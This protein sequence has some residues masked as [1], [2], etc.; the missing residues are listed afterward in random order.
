MSVRSSNVS[1]NDLLDQLKAIE[2]QCPSSSLIIYTPAQEHEQI[3]AGLCQAYLEGSYRE[4]QAIRDA[5]ANKK[6]VLNCFLGYLHQSAE[7]VRETRDLRWLRIGLAAAAIQ[8]NNYAYFYDFLLALAKLYVSAEEAGIDPKPEFEAMGSDIPEDFHSYAVV[9]ETRR[10]M[11][12][13]RAE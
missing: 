1:L 6:E 13:K 12:Y 7:R 2:D 3:F 10:R 9:E 5:V 11:K 4:R 8:Q